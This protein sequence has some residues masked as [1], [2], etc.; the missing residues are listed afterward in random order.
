M[1]CSK[2]RLWRGASVVVGYNK[3]SAL[4]MVG[5]RGKVGDEVLG[6]GEVKAPRSQRSGTIISV[7][8]EMSKN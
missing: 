6:G 3:V 4:M 8:F 1:G 5:G 7:H 2:L